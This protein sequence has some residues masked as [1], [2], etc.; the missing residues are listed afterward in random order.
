MFT[1][2]FTVGAGYFLYVN[3]AN[4]VYTK[5]LLARAGG[6]SS[7]AEEA[8]SLTTG[9]TTGGHI[10]VYAN[11][12]G[13]IGVNITSL[14][15][16]GPSGAT[17]ECMGVGLPSGCT[18]GAP[19]PVWVNVGGGS[20]VIDTGYTPASGDVYTIKVVTQRGS[21]FS[22]TYPAGATSLAA[23]ALSS[24]A[25]GDLYLQFGSYAYYNLTTSGCGSSS[26]WCMTTATGEPAF[27]IPSA[28]ATS[29]AM[30][31]SVVVT[32]L[33]PNQ[34]NI[35]LDQ[36]SVLQQMMLHGTTQKLV[37]W[38]L[39]S[40]SSTD[41]NNYYTPIVLSY[42]KP[43]FLLFAAAGP[44]CIQNQPSPTCTTFSSSGVS[45]LSCNSNQGPCPGITAPVFLVSHGCL[46][47]ELVKCSYSDGN[48][49]QNSPYVTTLYT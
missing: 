47:V 42:D 49:G 18:N 20:G 22:A 4:T 31:F 48:Y 11:N 35:T 46:G 28:V 1:M 7:Q 26:G 14:Y 44:V 37:T 43:T 19:F 21:V 10:S 16:L 6:I 45:A 5:A 36:F 38:Y 32:D 39:A 12:T 9:L 8:L 3:Q 2:L 30:A 33:N 25:I 24:G 13:G 34:L 29:N 15:L 40:N 23:R 17:L 41:I 27:S